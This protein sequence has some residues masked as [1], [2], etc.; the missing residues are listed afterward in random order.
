MDILRVAMKDITTDRFDRTVA[1][2]SLIAVAAI[3]TTICL[4]VPAKWIG[5]G[6]FF[7]AI[8]H[9]ALARTCRYA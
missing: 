8:I 7:S 2:A 6:R 4:S 5:D 1:N 3:G 9:P